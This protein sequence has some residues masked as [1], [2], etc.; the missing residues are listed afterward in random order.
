LTGSTLSLS[1][2]EV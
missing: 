2:A 1:N